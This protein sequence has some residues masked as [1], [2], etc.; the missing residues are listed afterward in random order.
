MRQIVG[1]HS[2]V[3][4]ELFYLETSSIPIEFILASRRLNYLHNVLTKNENELVKSVFLAQKINPNKGDWC[5]LVEKDMKLVNIKMTESEIMLMSKTKFKNHVKKC[6]AAAAFESLKCIQSEH[7]KVKH[8]EY[9]SLRIQPY[10][11]SA[12][13]SYEES[14]MLFNMRA[15]TVNGFKMCFPNFYKNNTFCM[16]GCLEQ[17]SIAHCFSCSVIDS[18]TC[19]TSVSVRNIFDTED[20]QKEAV[21]EFMERIK[22]RDSLL[23]DSASQGIILDTSTSAGAGRAGSG[24][25]GTVSLHI[26]TSSVT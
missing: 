15:D 2:K 5:L 16:L 20:K 10:M 6:V 11:I 26:T 21:T 18:Q 8:I 14:S 24:N 23:A 25:M 17:D 7:E 3:P 13:L 9:K 19:K 1:S 22:V 4:I 12:S